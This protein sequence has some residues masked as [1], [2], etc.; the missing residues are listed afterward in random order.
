MKK[1]KLLFLNYPNNPTAAVAEKSFF[2]E[3]W[4]SPAAMG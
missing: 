3:W 2:D 4:F 1:A